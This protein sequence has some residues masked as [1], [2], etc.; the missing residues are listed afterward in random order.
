MVKLNVTPFHA[1]KHV[2]HDA[3]VFADAER[4]ELLCVESF[5]LT[6]EIYIYSGFF[7]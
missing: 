4:V 2:E 1:A 7:G 3:G 6:S 5:K